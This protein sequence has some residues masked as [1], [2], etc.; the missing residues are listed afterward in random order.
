MIN[1]LSSSFMYTKIAN[2]ML[3]F[4]ADYRMGIVYAIIFICK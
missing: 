2:L 3:W 1:Y 4:Y